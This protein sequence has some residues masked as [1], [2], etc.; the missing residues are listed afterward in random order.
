MDDKDDQRRFTWILLST[1]SIVVVY[2]ASWGPLAFLAGVCDW[3][4]DGIIGA[5]WCPHFALAQ[6]LDTYEHYG[7][8]CYESGRNL[9][10]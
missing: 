9:R 2:L 1:A 7:Q 8:W 6:V 3:G 5:V 10:S 4:E